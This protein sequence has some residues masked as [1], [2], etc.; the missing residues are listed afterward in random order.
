[1]KAVKMMAYSALIL[2]FVMWISLLCYGFVLALFFVYYLPQITYY[3]EKHVHV[4]Y[5]RNAHMTFQHGTGF[6]IA[7]ALHNPF[8][9]WSGSRGHTVKV[10]YNA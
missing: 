9:A 6:D 10:S 7:S 4:V 2:C 8:M 5:V 3:F 1:M